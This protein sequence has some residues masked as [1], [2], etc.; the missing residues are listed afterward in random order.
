MI[1]GNAMFFLWLPQAEIQRRISNMVGKLFAIMLMT[2][3][4]TKRKK[5]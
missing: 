1:K 5:K 3:I 4:R 2:M